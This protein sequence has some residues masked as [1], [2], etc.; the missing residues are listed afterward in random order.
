MP[1][2]MEYIAKKFNEEI[3]PIGTA[4]YAQVA[5]DWLNNN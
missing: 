3:L 1:K 2:T 4:I 5:V